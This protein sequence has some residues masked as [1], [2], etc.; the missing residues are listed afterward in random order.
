MAD[1]SLRSLLA[2]REGIDQAIHDVEGYGYED[3]N[4]RLKAMRKEARE[5]FMLVDKYNNE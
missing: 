2:L 4:E 5:I 1:Y 3:V